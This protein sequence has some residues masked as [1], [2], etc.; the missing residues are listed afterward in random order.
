MARTSKLVLIWGPCKGPSAPEWMMSLANVV[1]AP[2]AWMSKCAGPY[3]N[4]ES[5]SELST[6]CAHVCP[7]GEN[8]T[9]L[10]M[11]VQLSFV[12]ASLAGRWARREGLDVL[13]RKQA[14]PAEQSG[15]R[16]HD[17]MPAMVESVRRP[18]A[19]H[20]SPTCT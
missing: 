3:S 7:E 12:L 5:V 16:L 13:V 19:Q 10:C 17:V 14:W 9:V 18:A 20:Q 11:T 8:A 4:F 1:F 15:A 2:C 6:R